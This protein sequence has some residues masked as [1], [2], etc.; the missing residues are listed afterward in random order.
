MRH[1]IDPDELQLERFVKSFRIVGDMGFA[2][3]NADAAALSCGTD[4]HGF[5]T[6]EPRKV[7]TERSSLSD[8]YRQVP[9][10][11][12]PLFERLL[13]SYRWATIDL[14]L[15]T[16]LANPMGPGLS[17]FATGVLRD[18]G[19]TE[20]LHP[21]GL[22]QFARPS[23]GEYDPVCFVTSK[24]TKDGDC[25]IVRVDHE[26]ILSLHRLDI[27][28]EVAPSFRSIVD[29]VVAMAEQIAAGGSE[30]QLPP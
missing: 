23:G 24:R 27:V 21:A 3:L 22:S 2:H 17:G 26:G 18:R 12:P 1:G 28:G 5:E 14:G 8:L 10:P 4:E 9:G 29:R 6:W 19:L 30:D 11:F 16:L 20:L 7:R 15:L 13:L 25:P